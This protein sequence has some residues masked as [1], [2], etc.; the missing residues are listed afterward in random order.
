MGGA[1][2]YVVVGSGAGGGVAAMVLAQ[3]GHGVVLLER[4]RNPFLGLERRDGIERVL[5]SNDE[6][7]GLRNF[8]NQDPLT[9]PRT[10]RP[11]TSSGDRT[12]T[13]AVQPLPFAV[14]GGTLTY[15]ADSPRPLPEDFRFLS[16]W[17]AV[18]G[19]E[20]VDWPLGYDDLEPYLSE[21]E[22][23]LGVQGDAAAN[24]FEPRRSAPYPMP[25]GYL[26]HDALL[27]A[28]GAERM[29][30]HPFPTPQAINSMAYRG[31][32]SCASCGF[33]PYG[34]PINAKGSTAVTAIRDALLTGRCELR[35]EC[36]ATR[37]VT[38]SAGKRVTGVEYLDPS[39]RLRVQEAGGV[40]L[41]C[42]PIETV[43]LLQL[44][45]SSLHPDGL[46]NSSGWLGQCLM[47]HINFMAVGVFDHRLHGYRGR[48]V[49]LEIADFR[50]NLADDPNYLFGG[51]VELGARLDPI[52]EALNYTWGPL[53]KTLMRE[54][55][56]RDKLTA[57]AMVGED[58][59][60]RSNRIDFDPRVR[61]AWGRPAPRITYQNHPRDLA[62]E[63]YFRPKLEE[64]MRLAG[65][66]LVF[67]VNINVRSGGIPSTNHILGG[68]RMGT[69][70]GASV[71]DSWGRFHD[72]ENL[73]CVDGSTWPTS[74]G[75]NPTLTFQALAYRTAASVVDP[76]DPA[77]VLASIGISP[78]AAARRAAARASVP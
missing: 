44:S 69:D 60:V 23:V 41:A 20:V 11:S 68:A 54:S 38:D 40:L 34:C 43:R 59:P 58:M 62:V 3:S 9:D 10:F 13:G 67:G 6:L 25:P 21:V 2:E 31:R 37:L 45:A 46:G 19:A 71:T 52:Q 16:T 8:L 73:W 65:A 76:A 26:K 1:V 64:M 70:P 17:G 15:D 5:L 47:F 35:A 55:W 53:H 7:K 77:R 28:A 75:V 14:G 22:W 50:R 48:P 27:I 29:G 74:T 56:F 72:L 24:P 4:G 30:L 78:V 66:D 18:P 32:P 51:V 63:S 36:L 39:G 42:N 57:T 33:C 49:T 61:D 12:F